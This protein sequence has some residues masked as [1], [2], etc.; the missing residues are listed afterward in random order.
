M[1][2]DHFSRYS[3]MHL[4]Q[5]TSAEETLQGKYDFERMEASHGI[6]IKQHQAENGIFR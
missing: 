5:T 2:V 6:I 4:Q 1:F 3:S